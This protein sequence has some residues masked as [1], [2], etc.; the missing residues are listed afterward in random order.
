M[1]TRQQGQ[2]MTD[3]IVIDYKVHKDLLAK[4][5]KENTFSILLIAIPAFTAF[6]LAMGMYFMQHSLKA[7]SIQL[8]LLKEQL[9]Q[10][11]VQLHKEYM[12]TRRTK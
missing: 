10:E 2:T 12:K 11:R 7:K 3:S 9:V 8:D 4:A 5:V 1:D 6:G